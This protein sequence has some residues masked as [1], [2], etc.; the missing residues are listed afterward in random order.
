[1]PLEEVKP[2]PQLRHL[3][4]PEAE[5]TRLIAWFRE[6]H[7]RSHPSQHAPQTQAHWL[8]IIGVR[9]VQHPALKAALLATS[10]A[11]W[12]QIECNHVLKQNGRRH[13][14][15][16]LELTQKALLRTEDALSDD[17]LAS[18]CVMTLYELADPSH[19]HSDG[20]LDHMV[21][22]G[23]L[24]CLRGPE[25]LASAE[26]R[27]VFEHTRYIFMIRC[28][29]TRTSCVFA[30][31]KWLQLPWNG[32]L[33]SVEQQVFDQ[34]LRLASLWRDCD[35][36]SAEESC[37]S[38]LNILLSTCVEI[39]ETLV[40][41]IAQIHYDTT[42]TN[43]ESNAS[44]ATSILSITVL[45]I[46][47]GVADSARKLL[48][49]ANAAIATVSGV[50]VAIS[51]TTSETIVRAQSL[52]RARKQLARSIFWS[53]EARMKMQVGGLGNSTLLWALQLA[54]EQFTP[55]DP[56]AEQCKAMLILLSQCTS[57]FDVLRLPLG[58]HASSPVYRSL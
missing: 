57:P 3:F 26:S 4:S 5:S 14:Q 48:A 7:I 16:S 47:L 51:D 11:K 22:T 28:L 19:R 38:G 27:A 55:A 25:G 9:H 46:Q 29:A 8:G 45:S 54:Q 40:P 41:L 52:D 2:Y 44:T 34:G 10:F 1:M 58:K 49:I 43:C 18:T 50:H 37:P 32:G 53:V 35:A 12:S 23:N 21:G 17:I 15:Q 36:L 39:F 56:E 42:Q 20:W 24:I 13:Y 30:S 33:K 6:V 31:R